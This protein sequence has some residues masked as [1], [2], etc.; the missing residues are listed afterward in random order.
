MDKPRWAA[1]GAAL[2]L[3]AG[4]CNAGSGAPS[5]SAIRLVEFRFEPDAIA[6]RT[7][8]QATVAVTNAGKQR[9]NLSIPALDVDVDYEPGQSS[10]LIFVAP[11]AAGQLEF[12]CKYHRDQG[13]RGLLV[14]RAR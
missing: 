9:H 3:A 2:L 14:V 10:N 7:G 4:A 1:A 5:A 6:A 11:P 13:M 12:F 8:A